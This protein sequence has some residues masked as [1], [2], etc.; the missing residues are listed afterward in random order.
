MTNT[1]ITKLFSTTLLAL[2]LAAC[3]S[4]DDGATATAGGMKAD[5]SSMSESVDGMSEEAK[6]LAAEAAAEAE[7]IAEAAME[8]VEAGVEAAGEAIDEAVVAG[9][10]MAAQAVEDAEEA[11]NEM[12][13][14]AAADAKAEAAAKMQKELDKFKNK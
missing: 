2:A 3:G 12:A 10:E 6:R 5:G 14:K 8:S 7:A 1:P 13:D 4:N 11:G 9:G